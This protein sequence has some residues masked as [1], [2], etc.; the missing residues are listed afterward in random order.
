MRS[1]NTD[2]GEQVA[3]QILVIARRDGLVPGARLVEQQLAD[4]IGVS[5]GPVR[6]GLKALE[7]VGL[8]TGQKNRGY[9]LAKSPTSHLARRT[10]G[11]LDNGDRVYHR[12][13][14]DRVGGRLPDV[15]TEA[16]LARRYELTRAELLRLL[17]RIAGEGWITKLQGYG[18]RFADTMAC[19]DAYAKATLFRAVIEPA[20]L[21]EP[22]Y[23]LSVDVIGKLRRE[24]TRLYTSGFGTLTMG[25]IFQSGCAFHEEIIRGA[26]NPFYLEALRRVNAIRRLL[27][28]RTFSDRE[29]MRRHIHEHLR[30]LD[31]IEAGKLSSAARIMQRHLA[32]PPRMD[33]VP[34]VWSE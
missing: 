31:L 7:Q 4:R 14:D 19:R 13:A 26:D 15:V 22:G 32:R 1:R 10:V 6:A 25:E 18:W 5:R 12:I 2:R 27:A 33:T 9:V 17:D 11:A 29:G 3:G 16:E 30:L 21:R 20:A 28:Y 24:Q 8:V 34:K 23:Q